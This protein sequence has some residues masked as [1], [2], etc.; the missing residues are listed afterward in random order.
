MVFSAVV[1]TIVTAAELGVEYWRDVAGIR[2]RVEQVERA[3]LPSIAESVAVADYDRLH[4]L[5]RILTQQPD[6]VLAEVHT[7]GNVLLRSDEMLSGNGVTRVFVLERTLREQRQPIGELVVQASYQAVRDRT[8]DRLV[9]FLGANLLKS[10]VFL[11]FFFWVFH[12]MI[13]R[14]LVHMT[15]SL[16][17]PEA[18]ALADRYPAQPDELGDLAGA[19]HT[20]RRRTAALEGEMA[21]RAAELQE[22]VAQRTNSLAETV[23]RFGKITA[24]LPGVVYQFCLHADG[25]TH[26]P[27]A[28]EGIRTIYRLSPESV[29][30][31]ASIVSTIIHPDDLAGVKASITTSARALSPWRHE[32]RV[33]FDD[34]TVRWLFGDALPQAEPD[35]SAMWFG[36]ITDITERK[37]VEDE[38]RMRKAELTKILDAFPGAALTVTAD[39]TLL[40]ANQRYAGLLGRSPQEL[41]GR[42]ASEF[43]T[44]DRL[45]SMRDH[46]DR[47]RDGDAIVFER[48]YPATDIHGAMTMLGSYVGGMTPGAVTGS[49]TSSPRMSPNSRRQNVPCARHATL[50]RRPAWPR[51][52]SWPA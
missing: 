4:S 11:G 3:A 5:L 35:G 51:V 40:Y 23:A 31:D 2:E 47:T 21:K 48:D 26:F 49:V 38:L 36:F 19:I 7:H 45:A 37:R 12:R 1:A 32:Y 28:S 24:Q 13:G 15:E 46:V 41:V 42:N 33:R 18:L 25:R 20:M 14:R 10:L 17:N 43:L 6:F 8:L 16:H 34:G 44:P 27:F 29:Q 22:R 9:L 39:L 30:R 52:N 50:R